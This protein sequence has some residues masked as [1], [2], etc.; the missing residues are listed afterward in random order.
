VAL[1]DFNL[2]T[3]I[4]VFT[5]N[6]NRYDGNVVKSDDEFI[7]L[8]GLRSQFMLFRWTEVAYLEWDV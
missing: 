6:S 5:K 8:K 4:S 1:Y 2:G 7:R 3:R